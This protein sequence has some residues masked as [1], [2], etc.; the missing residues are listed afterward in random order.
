MFLLPGFFFTIHCVITIVLVDRRELKAGARHGR[1]SDVVARYFV[2]ANTKRRSTRSRSSPSRCGRKP[3]GGWFGR[4]L[5]WF[6]WFW[7]LALPGGLFLANRR[8]RGV[9]RFFVKAIAVLLFLA[10]GKKFLHAT[11]AGVRLGDI[12]G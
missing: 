8:C 11:L 3:I 1:S 10:T 6:F 2:P 12:L 7:F 4:G 9:I 5:H